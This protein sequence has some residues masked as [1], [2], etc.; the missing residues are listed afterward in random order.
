MHV[1]R[2]KSRYVAKSG[3]ERV[4]ESVLLRRTYR[5]GGKVQA[6]DAGQPVAAARRCGRRA[7]GDAEGPDGSCPLSERVHASPGR[8]RTGT[9]PRSRRWRTQLGLPA[10]LG[11]AGRTRDIAV[12]LIIS[13]VIAAEV[14]AVHAGLV[15]RHHPG[16][17]SRRGRRVH[18][19]DLRRDGLAGRP[20]GGD[21]KEAR[22]Q[23]LA[24]GVNPGR[25]W[26]CSI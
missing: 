12:A 4:Y 19:R 16:D 22:G 21:R 20:A 5:E 13:R 18:R 10:L 2:N 8:C 7:G 9:W 25:G 6:R 23:D 1:A 11:P 3:R 15:A 26:R 24:P 17:R 14:E